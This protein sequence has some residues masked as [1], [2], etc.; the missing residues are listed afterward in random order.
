MKQQE[1]KLKR[2]SPLFWIGLVVGLVG[3]IDGYMF[4]AWRWD[5]PI[6][7]PGGPLQSL[8]KG[9]VAWEVSGHTLVGLGVCIMLTGVAMSRNR[10]HIL[11]EE[12]SP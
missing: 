3:Q 10:K 9:V 2:L 5:K 6:N 4:L 7:N 11:T 8:G 12:G 1:G